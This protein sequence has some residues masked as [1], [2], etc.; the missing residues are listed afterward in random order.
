M[1]EFYPNINLNPAMLPDHNN[2]INGTECN[3][4]AG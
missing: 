2:I 1:L 3:G 4:R